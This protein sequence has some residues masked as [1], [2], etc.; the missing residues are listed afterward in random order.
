MPSVT[1]ARTLY[2]ENVAGRVWEEA[3]QYLRLEYR[4]GPREE[5]QFRALLNHSAQALLRRRWSRILVDQRAMPPFSASEQAWM[6]THWLPQAVRQSGYRYG[7]VLMAHDVFARLAMNQLMMASRG[8][9][10]AYRAFE[11]EA[12]A[13]AWL[14]QVG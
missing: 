1:T 6:T 4:P 12:A 13:V 3:E 14:A 2:F 7:A 10:H 11:D 5:V 8:L 9:E